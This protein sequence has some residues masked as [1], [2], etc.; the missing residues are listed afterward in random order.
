M[1][2]RAP[3]QFESKP[4]VREQVPAL[5]GLFGPSG[6]GKT[7]SALRLATG[8]QSVTGGEIM[9]VDT[10]AKRALHYAD[11]FKFQHVEFK[12]PFGSL[13]YL[14]VLTWSVHKKGAK[15]VV[16]DSMSHEHEGPGGYL[17]LHET[18]LERKSGGDPDKAER[19][20]WGAWALP[21]ANRRALINGMLQLPASFVFCYRAKEKTTKEGKEIVQ[22]GFMPIAGDEFLFEMT[23]SALLLPNAGGVPTWKPEEPGSAVMVKQPG[24][25]K[26]LFA[27]REPLSEAHG[28]AIA[29]WARG[30]SKES[31]LTGRAG[32]FETKLRRAKN[33][34]E[35][36]STWER[37]SQLRSELAAAD[38]TRLDELGRLRDAREMEL[39]N[40]NATV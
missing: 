3:R 31:L 4:A 29:E 33:V 15:I 6:G 11:K 28:R 2:V 1:T 10:E 9:V 36:R 20:K 8:I 19:V 7:F 12:A 21:A 25:F 23:V 37:G 34:D 22:L 40:E 24:Q 18:E 26:E 32:V 27:T 30:D 39:T 5:V 38:Q 35:V 13:D 17:D 16:V 14:D